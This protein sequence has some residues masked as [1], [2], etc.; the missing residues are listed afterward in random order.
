VLVAYECF[1]SIKNRR[2]GNNG[3]CA[4]KLDMHKAYDRV[5]WGFLRD[6]MAKLGFDE[7]WVNMIMTCVTTVNYRVWFNSDETETFSPTRGLRQGDPLSPYLFLLC[8]EGLSSLLAYEE[9]NGGIQGI[10]VCRSAP[11]VSH[12]FFADDSLILMKADASNATSLRNALDMYC[13]SSGQLVSVAKSSIFFSP[14]TSAETREEVC[15]ILDILV[16]ALNDKYL[17]LPSLVGADRSDSFNY[18]IDRVWD[19]INGWNEKTLS[20]GA[21][22]VLLKAVAQA[23]PAY[24]MSVFNIPKQVCKSIC[25]AVARYWWGSTQEKKRMHWRAWWKMSV[26]KNKKGEWDSKI[27]IVSIKQCLQNNVEDCLVIRILYVHMYYG[28]SI[29]QMVIC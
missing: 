4:V 24:A 6:M 29:I 1:H 11:S 18:L 5:E 2:Q 20:T 19:L 8:G 10:R 3:T 7:R 26:P 23:I 16:E 25:D 21:K 27:Y 9:E 28:L 13:A 17:G 14:N 12:L 22:E 15:E